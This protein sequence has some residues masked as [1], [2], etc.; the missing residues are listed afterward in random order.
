MIMRQMRYGATVAAVVSA[1]GSGALR[2][3]TPADSLRQRCDRVTADV[4]AGRRDA[5][6][7]YGYVGECGARGMAALA[8]SW[9]VWKRATDRAALVRFANSTRLVRSTQVFDALLDVAGDETAIPAAR[10]LAL[11]NLRVMRDPAAHVP[12]ENLE[13]LA[14]ALAGPDRG[15]DADSYSLC[16]RNASVSDVFVPPGPAPSPEQLRRLSAM[17]DRLLASPATPPVVKAGAMCS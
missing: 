10:A 15:R 13:S 2:A 14:A 4:E 3:Q 17:R 1:L 5:V 16:G 6:D 11:R 9:G 7:A 8:H 12:L